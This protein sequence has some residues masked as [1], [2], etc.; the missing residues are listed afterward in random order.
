MVQAFLIGIGAGA[1]SALLF[2]SVASG[3]MLAV[4]LFYLAPLPILIAAI[5]WSHWAG[6]VAA[7][8]A[9]GALAA[10]LNG[11]F[12]VSFLV[13][14]GLPSWW[15]GYLALLAR[16]AP[17]G[18]GETLEWYPPGRLVFWAALLGAGVVL[19]AV[20][21]LYV[22]EE[23]FR[24]TLKAGLERMFS[25][26]EV[27]APP[28]IDVARLVDVLVIVIPPIAATLTTT[29]F[30]TNLWLAG[31]I[32]RISGRLKRGWPDLPAL[33][34]PTQ[35]LVLLA[36][37]VAGTFLPGLPGVV[38]GLFA[39]S[40]LIAYA[41]LGFS[42]AHTLTR[43]LPSRAL[44]L[45]GLYAAVAVFGWPVGILALLGIADAA[46]DLRGRFARRGAP[47]TSLT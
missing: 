32:V 2:A 14:V 20:P 18:G 10:T 45:G 29:T 38:A 16:P 44:V 36:A 28:S 34:L 46:F 42:V 39:A 9:A 17:N 11:F 40:L 12:F 7:L 26:T 4:L 25:A 43:A 8:V 31:L 33:T 37:S 35:G 15:L 24:A 21:F 5:G 27:G 13:G 1:A 19:V 41:V 47:P 22:D 6:L 23:S 30:L 3:A